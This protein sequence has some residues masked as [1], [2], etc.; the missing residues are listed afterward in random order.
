[1]A[2]VL[3]AGDGAALS[4]RS[5]AEL[6]GLIPGCSSP[7]HVTVTGAGGRARRPGLV[8]HRSRT[9]TTR[10]KGIPVTTPLR[11]L[12]D[13]KAAR[14]TFE[15]AVSEAQRTRL[16]S[17]AEADALLPDGKPAAN[18]FERRFLRICKEHGIPKPICQAEIGPYTVDFLWPAQFLI[19]ETD[20]HATHGTRTAFE[21]DRARDA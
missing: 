13:L 18:R 1:M 12:R 8:V 5:A 20:G 11:T 19:V 3:A 4:H 16:I 10:H 6:W 7:V 15:R 17:K 2:A 21:E 14:P 9:P